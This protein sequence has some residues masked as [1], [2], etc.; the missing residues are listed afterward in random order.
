MADLRENVICM[1]KQMNVTAEEL[2]IQP[3]VV[4]TQVPDKE[5][6]EYMKK[7]IADNDLEGEAKDYFPKEYWD[8][9][10][11][12]KYY[13]IVDVEVRKVISQTI[14][15]VIPQDADSMK[16]EEIVE[17]SI[18]V[19]GDD[20]YETEEDWYVYDKDIYDEELTEKEVNSYYSDEIFNSDYDYDE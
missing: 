3:K 16:A 6:L 10:E 5:L 11:L 20:D 17:S 2:G 13:K 18:S 9:L 4:V 8:D 14:R 12:N 7:F 15:V 1:A 19:I